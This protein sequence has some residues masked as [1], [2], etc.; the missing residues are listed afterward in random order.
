MMLPTLR[1]DAVVPAVLQAL[2]IYLT[3]ALVDG[4]TVPDV[5]E[6]RIRHWQTETVLDHTGTDAG[7]QVFR[8]LQHEIAPRV[9]SGGYEQWC[10]CAYQFLDAQLV[11]RWQPAWGYLD[12]LA[13][14]TVAQGILL[15]I[16]L[17]ALL[18]GCAEELQTARTAT[19]L[20]WAGY[21]IGLSNDLSSYEREV[22]EGTA[23]TANARGVLHMIGTTIGVSVD[24]QLT[25]S[26]VRRDMESAWA[27]LTQALGPPGDW[28]PLDGIIA[29]LAQ[30]LHSGYAK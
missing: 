23:S 7:Y 24:E 6:V 17:A 1:L 28:M 13:V 8:M 22:G 30:I 16:Q 29:R 4:A 2:W 21:Y 12:Y 15:T 19:L 27:H 10:A 20:R 5:L 3:D 25:E 9:S 18:A 11:Q 14:R 26:I